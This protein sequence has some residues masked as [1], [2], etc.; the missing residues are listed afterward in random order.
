LLT[1]A[2][3]FA[4]G[5]ALYP[6]AMLM[7]AYL[8]TRDQPMR[9]ALAFL[10]GA[11]LLTLIVGFAG[12]VVLR[13][14]GADSSRKGSVPAALDV[15]LGVALLVVAVVVARRPPRPKAPP[16][17]RRDMSLRRIFL[18][19]IAMYVPSIAYLS[20]LHSLAQGKESTWLSVVYVIVVAV[21]VLSLVEVPIILY[22]VAPE[23][24]VRVVGSWEAW[25]GRNRKTIV[26]VVSAAIG[27][28]LLG[29]GISKL[30]D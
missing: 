24:T 13:G 3:P 16:K 7:V 15:A 25:L 30:V 21:I 14:S 6:P 4:F 10:A 28:Y 20:A 18:V 17:E 23:Q 8:L 19:G 29:K 11:G 26:I 5:A 22:T 27:A 2:I 9:R 1:E 12:V